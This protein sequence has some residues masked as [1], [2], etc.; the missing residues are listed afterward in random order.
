M[1]SLRIIRLMDMMPPPPMPL[2]DLPT[3]MLVI[4]CERQQMI[5]PMVK[6]EIARRKIA[7]RPKTSDRAAMGGWKIAWVKRYDVAIQNV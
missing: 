7:C 4:P 3:S 1:M 2:I 5:E 6:S